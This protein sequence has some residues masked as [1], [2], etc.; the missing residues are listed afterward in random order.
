MPMRMITLHL[1]CAAALLAQA[2]N[3]PPP[4]SLAELEATAT[5]LFNRWKPLNDAFEAKF[6]PTGA[7]SKDLGGANLEQTCKTFSPSYEELRQTFAAMQEARTK[8]YA[9]G[10][11]QTRKDMEDVRHFSAKTSLGVADLGAQRETDSH[12]LDDYKKQRAD[13]AETLALIEKESGTAGQTYRETSES[14]RV[15]DGI[16][17][18]VN[19]RLKLLSE[20]QIDES[21]TMASKQAAIKVLE[22]RERLFSETMASIPRLS[23]EYDNYFRARWERQK[24]NC[25]DQ[26]PTPPPPCVPS[27]R[28]ACP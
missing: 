24:I 16:I 25:L 10:L 18:Q 5:A 20:I 2:P 26:I 3:A 27:P 17:D 9:K 19:S 4:A 22:E 15:L 23:T 21:A 6:Q 12:L 11:A 1:A 14:V 28:K 7:F 13:L 8:F